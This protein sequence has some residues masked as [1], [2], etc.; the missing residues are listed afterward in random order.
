MLHLATILRSDEREQA[1][2]LWRRRGKRAFD[3]DAPRS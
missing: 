1:Q 3:E 2:T